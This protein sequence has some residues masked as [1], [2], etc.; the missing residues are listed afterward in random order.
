MTKEE[1]DNSFHAI[2]LFLQSSE[3]YT[4]NG[5]E[6]ECEIF[7]TPSNPKTQPQKRNIWMTYNNKTPSYTLEDDIFMGYRFAKVI[8]SEDYEFAW[9]KPNKLLIITNEIFKLTFKRI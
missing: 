1:K 2:K 4:E 9:D 5:G 8:S 3:K 6:I 7:A